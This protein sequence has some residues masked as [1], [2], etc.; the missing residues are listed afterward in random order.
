[1]MEFKFSDYKNDP[2]KLITAKIRKWIIKPDFEKVQTPSQLFKEIER[3][4]KR[5]EYRTTSLFRDVI[6]LD[7]A[8]EISAKTR[9]T[10]LQLFKMIRFSIPI[11]IAN[12]MREKCTIHTREG[13]IFVLREPFRTKLLECYIN[14]IREGKTKLEFPK[15]FYKKE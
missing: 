14:Q 7:L 8:K 6:S 2:N 4:W 13:T 10:E 12:E 3:Q 9:L 15:E 1:M 11:E 5:V